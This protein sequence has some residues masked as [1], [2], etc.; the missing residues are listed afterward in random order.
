M[1]ITCKST[2]SGLQVDFTQKNPAVTSGSCW[3][4]YMRFLLNQRSATYHAK[5]RAILG[6]DEKNMG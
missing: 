6:A 3:V 5:G 4:F 2:E 1:I